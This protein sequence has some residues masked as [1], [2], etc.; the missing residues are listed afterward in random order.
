MTA[1]WNNTANA[2]TIQSLSV[3]PIILAMEVDLLP[4]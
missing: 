1:I 2:V 3:N 4:G